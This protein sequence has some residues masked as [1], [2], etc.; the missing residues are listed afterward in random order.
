MDSG[1]TLWVFIFSHGFTDRNNIHKGYVWAVDPLTHLYDWELRRSLSQIADG[2][3][4]TIVIEACCGGV[5]IDDLWALDNVKVIITATDWKS[6]AH[7]ASK[8]IDPPKMYKRIIDW[9]WNDTNI[10]DEG[11]E[12]S[13]G[14][15]EGLEELRRQFMDGE[16]NLGELYLQAFKI[17]KERDA[18]YQNGD[19]LERHYPT[20]RPKKRPNPL[21]NTVF[22]PGDKNY[23]GK[24]DILDIALA[25]KAFGSTPEHPRWN[26]IADVT[27]DGQIDILDIAAVA[28]YFGWEY[29]DS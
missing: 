21:L 7:S 28:Y 12:F 10:E 22:F 4:I 25:C 19:A 13:S 14:L 2:V 26:P 20:A 29:Y 11:G 27:K 8:G 23:D 9:D 15:M 1:D 17:A 5:F 6:V 16:I 18:G 24:V 3:N